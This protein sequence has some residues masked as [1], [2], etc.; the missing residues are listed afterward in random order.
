MRYCKLIFYRNVTDIV[1]F[2]FP[3]VIC[4]LT[5]SFGFLLY[6]YSLNSFIV[7]IS[8]PSIDVIISPS[9]IS[10]FDAGP[11]LLICAIY[12]PLLKFVVLFKLLPKVLFKLLFKY[13]ITSL[14][15]AYIPIV[16]CSNVPVFI[17]LSIIGFTTFIGTANPIPS[18]DVI[19]TVFIPYYFSI[20]IY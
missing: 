20:W 2:I 8:F 9:F 7:F 1:L 16:A 14:S 11:F 19:F 15:Y 13:G 12:I 17:K 18:A 10:V 5:I 6:I 4:K 3:L